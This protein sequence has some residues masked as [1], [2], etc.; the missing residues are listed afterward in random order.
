[1]AGKHAD[2]LLFNGSHADDLAWAREQVDMGRADRPD[3]RG[4][5]AL[6]AYA[7]VS[8]SEDADAAREAARPPVAFI[9][10]GAAPPVLDRHGLD[11]HLASDIGD[12]ISAGEFSEAFGLVTPE[13]IDAFSMAGTPDEVTDQMAAVLDYADGIVVGSPIGPDLEEAITLAA[14]AHRASQA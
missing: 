14:Q 7:S 12:K 5:F 1:M 13:M 11:A 3:S 4:D 9:T 8:I 2:G 6:A 10:A